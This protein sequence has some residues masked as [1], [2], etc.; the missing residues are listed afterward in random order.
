[1]RQ[2]AMRITG[3]YDVSSVT[4]SCNVV[5]TAKCT[6]HNRDI[7]LFREYRIGSRGRKNPVGM[8][9]LTTGNFLCVW[10]VFCTC[11]DSLENFWTVWKLTWQKVF[12]QSGKFPDSLVIFGPVSDSLKWFA[13]FCICREEKNYALLAHMLQKKFTHFIRK[14]FARKKPLSGKF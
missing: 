3:E 5:Y 10:K 6:L 11:L 9:A 7:L 4:A 13:H 8:S 1:M 2:C 14:V 12:G